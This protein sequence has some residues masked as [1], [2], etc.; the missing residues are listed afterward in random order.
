MDTIMQA[1]SRG[2]GDRKGRDRMNPDISCV[3]ALLREEMLL[4]QERIFL[5]SDNR[6]LQEILLLSLRPMM[7]H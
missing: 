7:F 1:L 2:Y 5:I 3:K 4:S 6:V